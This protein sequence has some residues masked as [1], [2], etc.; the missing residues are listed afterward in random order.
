MP[1]WKGKKVSSKQYFDFIQNVIRR[2]VGDSNGWGFT[3]IPKPHVIG[4]KKN[5]KRLPK[6]TRY[7]Y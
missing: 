1:K 3:Y 5:V 7:P 2:R 6:T 4:G